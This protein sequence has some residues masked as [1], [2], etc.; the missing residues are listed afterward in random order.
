MVGPQ[1]PGGHQDPVA[2][3]STQAEY[4][5]FD[6]ET[7]LDPYP[8]YKTLREQCPVYHNPHRGFWALSRYDD[9]RAASQDWRLFSSAEGVELDDAD[10]LFGIGEGDFLASDPPKHDAL[11]AVVRHHFVPKAI[12]KL[13]QTVCGI[14]DQLIAEISEAGGGDVVSISRTLPV[15]VMLRLFA[16]PL[17]DEPRIRQWFLDDL[18]TREPGEIQVPDRA[19][20]ASAAASE[21][22]DHMSADRRNHSGD[23]V[24]STLIAAER[25]G[26]LSREEVNGLAITLLAA[27]IKTTS[28]LISQTLLVLGQQ[29]E[30]Q[31]RVL[32]D[33][34][35]VPVAVEESLRF[36][37]PAQW[38]ARVTTEDVTLHGETIP[39]GARVALLYGSAN[40]DERRFEEPDRFDLDREPHRHLGFGN[41]IHFCIGAPLARLE[42]QCVLQMLARRIASYE[43]TGT[44][45]RIYSPAERDLASLPVTVEAR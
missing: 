7:N 35:L 5:P 43:I 13:E 10:E 18:F 24:L 31:R 37:A 11:R 19:R 45:E 30:D 16:L 4:D 44:V 9:I 29:P 27:A 22:I 41:G 25:A 39:Q 28:G 1:F 23:D 3:S 12:S 40:R 32:E 17:D 42:T 38:L 8:V 26:N 36:D 14:A 6:L 21:Y 15:A 33:D 34:R 2:A 20:E